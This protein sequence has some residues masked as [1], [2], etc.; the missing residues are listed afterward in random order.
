[1]IRFIL[2]MQLVYL[3]G[4]SLSGN[5]TEMPIFMDTDFSMLVTGKFGF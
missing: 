2:A 4:N 1:M 3:I 5:V